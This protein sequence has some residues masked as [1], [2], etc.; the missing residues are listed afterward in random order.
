MA[1]DAVQAA[2]ENERLL[3]KRYMS[4]SETNHG[5]ALFEA[6]RRLY[7]MPELPA[8][9]Y[10]FVATQ[11]TAHSSHGNDSVWEWDDEEVYWMLE[12]VEL[13]DG[14][15]HCCK[16]VR[17]GDAWGL[18]HVLRGADREGLTDM[19]ALLSKFPRALFPGGDPQPDP[20]NP[21]SVFTVMTSLQE[22]CLHHRRWQGAPSRIGLRHDVLVDAPDMVS[23]VQTFADHIV[24][25]VERVVEAS[26]ANSTKGVLL[27][28]SSPS[29]NWTWAAQARYSIPHRSPYDRVRVVN[30]DP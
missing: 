1:S 4:E 18:P 19:R 27:T 15:A 14:N 28:P 12:D 10:F 11:L 9:P 29:E 20:R 5:P 2:I 22:G 16:L 7:S 26:E 24:D 23:A 6:M 30:V 25:T 3:R 8:N 13:V 21:D 17:W